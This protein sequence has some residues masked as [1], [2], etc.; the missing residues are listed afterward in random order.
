MKLGLRGGFL[1]FGEAD[2]IRWGEG[3]VYLGER[4]FVLGIL[5]ISHEFPKTSTQICIYSDYTLFSI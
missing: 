5:S 3:D 1:D 4:K 2:R